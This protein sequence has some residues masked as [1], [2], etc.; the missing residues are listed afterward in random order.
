[1]SEIVLGTPQYPLIDVQTDRIGQ[2]THKRML[3]VRADASQ[4]IRLETNIEAPKG[5]SLNDYAYGMYIRNLPVRSM[6]QAANDEIDKR[7]RSNNWSQKT[8]VSGFLGAPGTGKTF[9][10]NNLGRLVHK[11]GALLIDCSAKDAKTLFE[12][13]EFDTASADEEKAL[14]D[15]KIMYR[16]RGEANGLSN[17]SLASLRQIAGSAVKEDENGR[18]TVDWSAIRFEGSNVREYE[19][20]MHIFQSTLRD[21]CKKEGLALHQNGTDIGI[22]MKDGELFRVFDPTSPD[23]GRP[24]ILDE[25]NRA[26]FG[27]LD[28]LYGLLNFLNSPS[29]K[30]FKITGANNREIM[31]DKEKIP[32]T[33]YLNFTGNQA[34][35]GMGS[36]AFNDPFL[37]RVPEGFTLKTIPDLTAGDYADMICSYLLGGV[38]GVIL[39]DAYGV[40]NSPQKQKTFSSFLKSVREVGLTPEEIREIP[41]WQKYNLA[42]AGKII[43]LSEKFGR[44]LF[45]IK[46]LAHLRGPYQKIEAQLPDIGPEYTAYLSKKM[47]DFRIIPYFFTE[48]EHM[49]APV[50]SMN[51]FPM[52]SSDENVQGNAVRKSGDKLERYASRGERLEQVIYQWL[53]TTF[54]PKDKGIRHIEEKEADIMYKQALEVA[55]LNNIFPKPKTEARNNGETLANLY[56]VE[57]KDMSDNDV[58]LDLRDAM[59]EVLKQAYPDDLK[60]EAADDILPVSTVA[61]TMRNLAKTDKDAE[62]LLVLNENPV[63]VK[64]KLFTPADNQESGR[65]ISIENLLLSLSLDELRKQNIQALMAMSPIQKLVQQDN[66]DSVEE[67]KKFQIAFVK[68]EN[69]AD[70]SPSYVWILY[71][72]E[73]DKLLVIGDSV[74]PVV[75]QRFSRSNN[76]MYIDRQTITSSENFENVLEQFFEDDMFVFEDKLCDK[77]SYTDGSFDEMVRNSET[78]K[79]KAQPLSASPDA[80]KN[81]MSFLQRTGVSR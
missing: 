80:H 78:I 15:M 54:L 25:L 29:M 35:D 7:N 8:L 62:Q 11:K 20:N 1:M 75:A 36:Q 55:Y 76:R 12:N 32:G 24:V 26:K 38:P 79:D 63:S 68:T 19:H 65:L 14:I 13:P 60:N 64:A 50:S 45:E 16:N 9:Y 71:N 37:S 23:Y 41:E 77:L 66:S 58:V 40:S 61:A 3:G 18:I 22:V 53:D 17:E 10:F 57:V 28:N 59:V 44:F 43:E 33:F 30:K 69:A 5:V 51:D 47:I 27:T 56:N 73:S 31:V 72:K 4:P 42:N 48:A 81:K 70:H 2:K 34:V 6:L 52:F 39:R 67:I 49:K 21:I 46:E 74:H